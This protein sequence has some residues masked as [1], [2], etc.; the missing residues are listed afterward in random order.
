LNR[1]GTFSVLQPPSH[2]QE[3]PHPLQPLQL[4][5][6]FFLF[7]ISFHTQAAHRS[8]TIPTTTM[9]TTIIRLLRREFYQA[10]RLSVSACL[11]VPAFSC[12]ICAV[13]RVAVFGCFEK[14]ND[15]PNSNNHQDR[16]NNQ[17]DR[18]RPIDRNIKFHKHHLPV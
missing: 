1:S 18:I 11:P 12:L 13:L 14:A 6:P 2:P 4:E 16:Q 17:D 7:E 15:N 3:L 10:S 8:S 5:M 9:S